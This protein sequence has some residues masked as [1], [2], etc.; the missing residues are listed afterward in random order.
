VIEKG[1][2]ADLL[3]VEGNPI[4]DIHLLEDAETN[5][6]LIMKDGT[7]FRNRLSS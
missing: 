1:A 4:E 7:I 2:L 6:A 5:L 3:V